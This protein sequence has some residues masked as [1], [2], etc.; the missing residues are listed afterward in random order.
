MSIIP[1]ELYYYVGEK[2]PALPCQYETDAG[3]PIISI[4]GATLTAKCKVDEAA[5]FNV[6]CTNADDGTFTINWSTVTS[7]FAVAGAMRIG[8]LVA[9]GDY[10]WYMPLFSIPIK[11]R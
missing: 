3:I 2:P 5:E 9:L 10:E 7:S 4:A 11:A 1:R 6:T 8:V